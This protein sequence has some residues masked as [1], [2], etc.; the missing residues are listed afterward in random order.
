MSIRAV[1]VGTGGHAQM[2]WAVS[3]LFAKDYQIIAWLEA[4]GYQGP[5]HL[6]ELPVLV[7]GT[8][9]IDVLKT[10]G[11]TAFMFGLGTI[12]AKPPRWEL[13]ELLRSKGLRPLSLVHP[14]AIVA[15]E[16][17]IGEGVFVGANVVIQPFA[18]I[19]DACIVNTGA[20]IEHHVVLGKN[21]HAAPG[22]VICGQVEIGEHSLIGAGSTVIQGLKIGAAATVGAGSTVIR[23]VPGGETVM[24]TPAKPVPVKDLQLS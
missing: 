4:P 11:C 2:M 5:S 23:N 20:I 6:M 1:M 22:S 19:G 13:F 9:Q 12:Q 18:R 8:E 17:E 24:G 16:A 7:Q 10:Q 15:P 14:A 3:R 21:V